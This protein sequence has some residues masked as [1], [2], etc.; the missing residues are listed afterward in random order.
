MAALA[1]EIGI[2]VIMRTR[3][4]V[5]VRVAGLGPP[6][7]RLR[8]SQT[9]GCLIHLE[10]TIRRQRLPDTDS[11]VELAGSWDHH[12]LTD[13]EHGLEEVSEPVFVRTKGA[14]VSIELRPAEAQQLKKIARSRGVGETTILRR[15][16][17]ERLHEQA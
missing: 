2:G 17:L 5:I 8:R 16:I 12:D 11:V 13:F 14:S 4:T 7:W 15:W 3:R 10:K 6:P 9:S 1:E